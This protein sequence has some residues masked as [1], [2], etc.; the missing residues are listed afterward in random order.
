VIKAG[1]SLAGWATGAAYVTASK[2]G[3]MTSSFM[4]ATLYVGYVM[5]R[6]V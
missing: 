6:I 1:D 5:I 2:T 3:A 4:S